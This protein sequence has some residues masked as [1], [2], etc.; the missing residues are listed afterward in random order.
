LHS[1]A[2]DILLDS[3]KKGEI[4]KIIFKRGE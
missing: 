4:R 2:E 1:I 3:K